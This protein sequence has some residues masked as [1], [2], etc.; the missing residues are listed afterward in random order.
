MVDHTIIWM[1][2]CNLTCGQRADTNISQFLQSISKVICTVCH[3]T[4]STIFTMSFEVNFVVFAFN[5]LIFFNPVV[6]WARNALVVEFMLDFVCVTFHTFTVFYDFNLVTFNALILLPY[7]PTMASLALVVFKYFIY[8]TLLAFA[9]FNSLA[10]W[11]RLAPFPLPTH[12][13]WYCHLICLQRPNHLRHLIFDF[14]FLIFLHRFYHFHSDFLAATCPYHFI[15]FI[16]LYCQPAIYHPCHDRPYL[17]QAHP[18]QAR[19]P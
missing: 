9:F 19:P 5:A 11:A 6:I 10:V 4:I 15:Q 12:L 2:R 13:Y 3:I 14:H 7:L 17:A 8:P 1:W 18:D 16:G